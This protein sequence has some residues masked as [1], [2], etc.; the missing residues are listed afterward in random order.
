M[1]H[2]NIISIICIKIIQLNK[3][4]LLLPA[5]PDPNSKQHPTPYN[6]SRNIDNKILDKP[7]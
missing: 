4:L 2:I 3:N 1:I 7:H 6:P 5:N